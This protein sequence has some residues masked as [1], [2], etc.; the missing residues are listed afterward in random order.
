MVGGSYCMINY[1]D[2]HYDYD[3]TQAERG[4]WNYNTKTAME[5]IIKE[6]GYEVVEMKQFRPGA[7]YAVFKKPGNENLVIYK[8]S[9]ISID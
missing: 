5:N 6:T 9:E 8:S 1:A 4:Y 2:C 7:N 3:L